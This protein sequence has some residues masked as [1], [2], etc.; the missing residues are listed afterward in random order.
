[1][2]ILQGGAFGTAMWLDMVN[3]IVFVGMVTQMGAL[4][5]D[6]NLRQAAARAIY[7]GLR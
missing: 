2:A 6:G 4:S 1:M 5:G 3:K 7:E